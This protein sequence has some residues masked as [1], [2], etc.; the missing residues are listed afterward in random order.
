MR[1]T[2]MSESNS[3]EINGSLATMEEKRR[4]NAPNMKTDGLSNTI[5]AK[6]LGIT[7]TEIEK[8]LNE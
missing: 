4:K 6:Y 5:I 7:E 1:D 3:S 2:F 8:L